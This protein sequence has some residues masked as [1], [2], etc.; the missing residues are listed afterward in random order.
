M[1]V[2]LGKSEKC[3]IIFT[4]AILEVEICGT[5]SKYSKN[6]RKIFKNSSLE[7]MQ[8]KIKNPRILDAEIYYDPM[9]GRTSEE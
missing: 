4:K 3:K 1:N 6:L 9:L 7:F 5:Y 8:N 2:R